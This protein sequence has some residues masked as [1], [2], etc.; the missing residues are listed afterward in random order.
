MMG[1]FKKMSLMHSSLSRKIYDISL[2]HLLF[3]FFCSGGLKLVVKG[4]NFGI[5]NSYSLNLRTSETS[6]TIQTVFFSRKKKT[7]SFYRFYK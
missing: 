4:T 6:E 5:E 2:Y 7:L 1:L 3:S